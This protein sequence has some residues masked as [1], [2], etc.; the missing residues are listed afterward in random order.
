MDELTIPTV[1]LEASILLSSGD[2]VRGVIFLPAAASHHH[3]PERAEEWLNEPEP[4]FGFQPQGEARAL[5]LN[6]RQV[7][8]VTVPASA[9]EG[10]V[11]AEVEIPLHPVV[12]QL[13]GR[14]VSGSVLVDMPPERMRVRDVLNRPEDFVTIRDGEQHHI[15]QKRRIVHVEEEQ[16][17]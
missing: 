7:L 16:T 8:V 14:R 1:T 11:P 10:D 3:G 2:E 17:R 12:V 9:D 6:K 4:F 15:V 13:P 5:I